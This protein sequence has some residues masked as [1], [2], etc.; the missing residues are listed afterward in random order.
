[1]Y[2]VLS[3]L[4]RAPRTNL[5]CRDKV[6]QDGVQQLLGH[7]VP[8]TDDGAHQVHHMHVHLLVVTIAD[9]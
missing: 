8:L 1:M 7:S 4:L 5:V 3:R 2:S 9:E 6:D